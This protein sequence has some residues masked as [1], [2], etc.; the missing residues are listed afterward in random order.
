MQIFDDNFLG[1]SGQKPPFFLR[2]M[3]LAGHHEKQVPRLLRQHQS[4][5]IVCLNRLLT[6]AQPL[7][8]F[9]GIKDLPRR[10]LKTQVERKSRPGNFP[11]IHLGVD[12]NH[13][14]N[15]ILQSLRLLVFRAV[16]A[17]APP[18]LCEIVQNRTF[19]GDDPCFL[20]GFLPPA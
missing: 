5:S 9:D 4:F 1:V 10:G 19:L 7:A 2:K 20:I 8:N 17:D 6:R 14:A 15:S 12:E 3:T 16:L 13:I 18:A 11:H